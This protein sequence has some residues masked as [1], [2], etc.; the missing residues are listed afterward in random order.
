MDSVL[1][2]GL[3]LAPIIFM[4][5]AD[6]LQW[7]LLGLSYEYLKMQYKST[8]SPD[9]FIKWLRSV[10][11]KHKAWHKKFGSISRKYSTNKYSNE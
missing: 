5:V 1:P 6:A 9:E 10:G 7:E 11:V 8:S 4:A 3:R 2:F